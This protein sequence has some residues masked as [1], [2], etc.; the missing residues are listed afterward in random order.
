MPAP[1]G[2][3][4]SFV[5]QSNDA[6]TP[7]R[8]QDRHAEEAAWIDTNHDGVCSDAEIEAWMRAKHII[9]PAPAQGNVPRLVEEY[10][11]HLA[12][13]SMRD[14]APGYHSLDE[15]NATLQK[16]AADHPD[17]AQLVSIGKSVEGRDIWALKVSSKAAGDTS[18]KPGVV[19]TGT[20]HA[21]EWMT[22]EVT[23]GLAEDLVNNYDSNPDMKRRVDNAEIWILPVVNPDGFVYSQTEDNM[24]RKNRAPI[25][26]VCSTGQPPSGGAL[27][28]AKDGDPIAYG[29]DLNRNYWDGNPAHLSMYRPDGDK[30]CDT[31]DDFGA[32]DDPDDD[33]FRGIAPGSEPEVQALMKFE[34]GRANIH[35]IMDHHSYVR[36]LM[37]PWDQ[38][39]DAP[40]DV[41]DYDDIAAHMRTAQGDN[42]YDYIQ[43]Y[44]LYPTTGASASCHEA[45][46]RYGMAMEMGDSFQ[47]PYSEYDA[48]YKAVAP[49]DFALVD[50]IINKFPTAPPAGG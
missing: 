25:P 11:Q 8:V 26:D 4:R 38:I 30:P 23:L 6:R 12:G 10:K 27:P 42:P 36:L 21:R 37:R 32:S 43:T 24:W 19:F 20:H 50:W 46:G 22:P 28:S 35:A 15:I 1:I 31:S 3:S 39:P 33:S 7:I 9:K 45:N 29:V 2:P 34:Y 13:R 49:A 40:A 44:Q 14:S 41:K 18:N 48:H 5:L 47:P 17:R 16:L